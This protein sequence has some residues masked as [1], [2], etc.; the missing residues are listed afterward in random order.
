MVKHRTVTESGG[1]CSDATSEAAGLGDPSGW[2]PWACCKGG[3]GGTLLSRSSA[4]LTSS[5]DEGGMPEGQHGGQVSSKPL[6]PERR[7]EVEFCPWPDPALTQ[8]LLP[9]SLGTALVGV[10]VFEGLIKVLGLYMKLGF[11][12]TSV[13]LLKPL[14]RTVPMQPR[15]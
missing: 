5:C 9:W 13:L 7:L 4:L 15:F 6:C 8:D 12:K 10:L 14:A 2:C 3:S 1:V 11:M